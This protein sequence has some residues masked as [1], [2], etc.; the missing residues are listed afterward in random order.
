M[1]KLAKKKIDSSDVELKI[2]NNVVNI[3]GKK[4]ILNLKLMKGLSITIEDNKVLVQ[5]EKMLKGAYLGLYWSLLKNAIIGVREGFEKRLT[6]IGVGFRAFVKGKKLDL[7][8][9]YSH[10]TQIDIPEGI[11]VKVESSEIIIKGIDKMK[12][13]QFASDVRA[14][15]PPE[16]YKGKGIRYKDE[17]VKKKAGKSA[18]GKGIA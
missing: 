10:P 18:K 5:K 15:K 3:K 12:V 13:G 2:E 11:E 16:P 1:S 6:L 7:Q 9:G 8:V 17:Y 4:G 14:I